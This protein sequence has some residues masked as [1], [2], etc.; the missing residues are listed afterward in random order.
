MSTTIRR[1][2][3]QIFH[4]NLACVP[5]ARQLAQEKK[6]IQEPI[7]R[8]K[9][10]DKTEAPFLS[11]KVSSSQTVSDFAAAKIRALSSASKALFSLISVL[12]SRWSL[13]VKGY[14]PQPPYTSQLQILLRP[15][16][17][18]HLVRFSCL[19]S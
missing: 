12:F 16:Y 6:P 18:G 15:P 1:E 13:N 4:S 2:T 9:A 7:I 10:D 17:L 8:R 19:V 14:T 3:L 11:I 5:C